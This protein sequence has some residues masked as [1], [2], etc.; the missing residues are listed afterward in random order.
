MLTIQLPH[1]P[2]GLTL[3]LIDYGGD[4]P[5]IEEENLLTL[6]KIIYLFPH[7]INK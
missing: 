6:R 7:D 1:I 2:Y 3:T 5:L 4:S